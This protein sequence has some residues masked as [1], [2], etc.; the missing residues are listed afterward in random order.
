MTTC[1]LPDPSPEVER[2]QSYVALLRETVSHALGAQ[3]IRHDF[4]LESLICRCAELE[5]RAGCEL[6]DL[7][8]RERN[9]K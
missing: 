2:L 8:Q 9:T 1:P 5:R 4:G 3:S 7:L 6:V